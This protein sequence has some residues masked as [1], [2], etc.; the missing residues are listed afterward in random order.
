HLLCCIPVGLPAKRGA[1]TDESCNRE[2]G[3]ATQ[4]A[5]ANRRPV[6]C[7][8]TVVESGAMR[9]MD[10]RLHGLPTRA[11]IGS[12]VR[13]L[14]RPAGRSFFGRQQLFL[15]EWWALRV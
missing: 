5:P 4:H 6:A 15:R 3:K 8:L 10:R 12:G 13:I 14:R 1:D 2:P 9:R 7:D 11:Q